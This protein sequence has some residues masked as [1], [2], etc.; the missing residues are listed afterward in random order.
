[1]KCFKYTNRPKSY[2]T[3]KLL[4]E[5]HGEG[6]DSVVSIGCTLKGDMQNPTWKVHVPVDL[7]ESVGQELV[8]IARAAREE[9]SKAGAQITRAPVLRKC[10]DPSPP[11]QRAVPL[12][13]D[14]MKAHTDKAVDEGRVVKRSKRES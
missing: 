7:A 3:V 12:T 8:R 13:P 4:H 5:P 10:E 11:E 9:K 2:I 14:E 1:M 6:T